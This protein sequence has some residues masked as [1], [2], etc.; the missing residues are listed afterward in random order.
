MIRKSQISL[1]IGVLTFFVGLVS[2]E[3]LPPNVWSDQDIMSA[4]L[5]RDGTYIGLLRAVKESDESPRI[6]VFTVPD[7]ELVHRQL[8]DPMRIQGFYWINDEKFVMFLTQQIRRRIEGF[9]QGV[10]GGRV[11]VVDVNAKK[12]SSFSVDAPPSMVHLLPEEPDKIIVAMRDDRRRPRGIFE[13]DLKGGGKRLITREQIAIGNIQVNKEGVPIIASGFDRNDKASVYLYRPPGTKEWKEYYRL[14]IDDFEF[15]SYVGEDTDVPG[16][17]LVVANNGHD[18]IGLWSFNPKTKSFGELI[19]RHE[20]VDVL[21]PIYHSN[22]WQQP[23]TIVGIRTYYQGDYQ[24][25]YWDGN[26]GAIYDS[27]ANSIQNVGRLSYSTSYDGSTYLILN[28]GPKEPPTYYLLHGGKL[29]VIG[30]AYP[31]IK[32]GD[33]GE[34]QYIEWKARD[35]RTIPGLLTLPATGEPP[36]PLVVMP[37]G[38]PYVAEISNFHPWVGILSNHGYAVLQPQYRGSLNF[39]QEHY[40]SAFRPKSEA[41][42]KMQDD[43]DDGAIYLI[44]SGM[45]DENRVAMYGWSYGGYAALVAAM[46]E[47][48]IYQCAIAGA[49][50]S[51]PVMQVNYYRDRIIGRQREEQLTTWLGAFS[52][53]KNLKDVNVPLLI[54]HGALDQRVP[55]SHAKKVV[56]GLEANA[57]PHKYVEIDGIDHFSNTMYYT[58][59]NILWEEIL[60]YLKEDC[61]PGGL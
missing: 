20:R 12:E 30:S 23:D 56:S 11:V 28:S 1:L 37:H 17:F 36:Y 13:L 51:D 32:A 47:P 35:G 31:R 22:S 10:Y 46:R 18:K 48:Q 42:F 16:N 52:P 9:N 50:V 60:S 55:L 5:S 45:V 54:I 25:E 7:M 29:S 26:E 15:F 61:G 41:G 58:H 19:Y 27:L 49:A 8:S 59:R 2:A 33:V 43:K 14:K 4:Q 53:F 39:G 57:V 44:K 34:R 6:E 21:G 3:P 24:N 38:G 40:T